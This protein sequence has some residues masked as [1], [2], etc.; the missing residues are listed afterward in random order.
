MDMHIYIQVL[1]ICTSCNMAV[2]FQSNSKVYT[3]IYIESGHM[4]AELHVA[5]FFETFKIYILKFLKIQ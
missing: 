4:E 3:S 2:T 5:N 1:G